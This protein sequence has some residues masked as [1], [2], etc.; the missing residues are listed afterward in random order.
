MSDLASSV[1]RIRAEVSTEADRIAVRETIL[2][3]LEALTTSLEIPVTPEVDVIDGA[4]RIVIG[5]AAPPFGSGAPARTALQP[6]DVWCYAEQFLTPDVSG[7]IWRH[8]SPSRSADSIR[9]DFL[10]RFRRMLMEAVRLGFR[11]GRFC[12]IGNRLPVN[13]TRTDCDTCFEDVISDA[14]PARVRLYLS[15]EQYQQLIVSTEG[16]DANWDGLVTYLN[17][18]LFVELGIHFPRLSVHI[19]DALRAPWFRCEWNDLRLAPRLGIGSHELLVNDTVDKLQIIEVEGVAFENPATRQPHAIVPKELKARLES[20]GLT[21]WDA[22]GYLIL[23]VADVLRSGAGAFLSTPAIEWSLL[24]L[25]PFA[26][27]LV[28]ATRARVPSQTL[29]RILRGLVSEQVSIRDLQTIASA[30]IMVEASVPVDGRRL[31]CFTQLG[32][33]YVTGP[34]RSVRELS[35]E[36]YVEVARRSLKGALSEKL[37]RGTGTLVVYLLDPQIERRLGASSELSAQDREKLVAGVQAEAA[38]LPPTAQVPVLLVASDV[39]ARLQQ[40]LFPELR[41]YMVSSHDE[42]TPQL[43]VQPV[44]RITAAFD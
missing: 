34:V 40:A 9:P 32:T 44:A 2:P 30:L 19:D 11:L 6:H 10:A 27:E 16:E 23:A 33:T 26:P 3:A 38:H 31:V 18:G 12:E 7:R 36:D 42:L 5:Q 22:R 8:W 43:N 14:A 25:E 37:A 13:P 17:D 41:H 21:T 1:V 24:R 15:R 35:P 4:G 29:V 28:A 39:R 20:K